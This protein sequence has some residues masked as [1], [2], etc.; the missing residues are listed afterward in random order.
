MATTI[1]QTFIDELLTRIDIVEIIEIYVT[2]QKAGRDY[3]ACCPFHHE[4][5]PSFT[6]SPRKQFYYCF[7]CGAHGNA[8]KFLMEHQHLGFVEAIEHL[9][10]RAG[11][12]VPTQQNPG[13]SKT[14]ERSNDFYKVLDKVAQFYRYQLKNHPQK[15]QVIDYLRNR[16]L[17]GDIC[18]KFSVGFAPPGW[19][20][21]LPQ[22]KT[23]QKELMATG[24]LSQNNQ[25]THD[26]F[27]NRIMFPIRDRQGRV[28]A[29]GGRVLDDATPKYLNS[30]ETS[31]F[32]KSQ[33]LY[34]LYE[35]LQTSG[36]LEKLVVV[37]GYLDVIALAQLEVP[38]T[39]ATLGT[40]L[41]VQHLRRLFRLVNQV[42][43][44]FDGDAAG[45]RA[46]WRALEIALPLAD[47]DRELRFLVLPAGDDPDSYIRKVG[48]AGFEKAIENS[49]PLTTFLL[50]HLMQQV[51]LSTLDGKAK[52]VKLAEPL[53]QQ[54]PAGARKMLLWEQLAI[55][56]GLTLTE[57]KKLHGTKESKT[58][59]KVQR[60]IN[61]KLG[62]TLTP[63]Q[64]LLS[65]L[66]QYPKLI[67]HL[68]KNFQLSYQDS[69]DLQLLNELTA[70]LRIQP[71]IHTGTLLTN[72]QE[73]EQLNYLAALSAWEHLLSDEQLIEETA[74]ILEKLKQSEQDQQLFQLQQKIIQHGINNLTEDEKNLLRRLTNRHSDLES[75]HSQ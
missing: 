37:E 40:A 4:K 63:L 51:D 22:F 58:H 24:M 35:A 59:E 73:S 6:V 52:F 56:T 27:R 47:D 23:N 2:L 46:A 18:Q 8:L 12:L 38:Y 21:L 68:P 55:T 10:N 65:L 34:G 32:H 15:D 43:F 19:D 16:G 3:K 20:N 60:P 5:T 39:V 31:I 42:V 61:K 64:R 30:P 9:A 74:G 1:P 41:N 25:K 54:L 7:G 17:T 75:N 50:Q 33:E 48:K 72:W 36:K 26:R 53:I 62:I 29:F 67:L 66:L 45:Q 70:I 14:K 11:M 57:I 69:T 13:L 44:C 71:D 28:I 49:Q